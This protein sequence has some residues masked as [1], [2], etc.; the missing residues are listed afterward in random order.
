MNGTD[1]I[2]NL[3]LPVHQAIRRHVKWP[4]AE[5]TEIYNCAYE[6]ALH[7][8]DDMQVIAQERNSLQA[9]LDKANAANNFVVCSFCEQKFPRQGDYI[10]QIAAHIQECEKHPMRQVEEDNAELITMAKKAQAERDALHKQ[11]I[12]MQA[13]SAKVGVMALKTDRGYQEVVDALRAELAALREAAKWVSECWGKSDQEWYRP[14][15]DDAMEKLNELLPKGT[16]DG[17]IN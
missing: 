4:S 11:L 14:D 7:L 8:F 15:M 5:H 10:G 13:W 9:S 17:K 1:T 16:N 2:D 3:M 12:D 6:V